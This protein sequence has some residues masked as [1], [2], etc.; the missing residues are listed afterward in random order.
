MLLRVI[1][2]GP[3]PEKVL[4]AIR[5]EMP[6]VYPKMKV[7][8]LDPLPI[9]KEAY[10]QWRKQYDAEKIMEILGKE[11]PA[12][13][14]DEEVPTLLV[15][16]YDLY[17]KNMSFVFVLEDTQLKSGI[18][19]IARLRPEFYGER[20]SIKRLSERAVKEAVHVIGHYLGLSHCRHPFCVMAF[21]PSAEDIDR[22]QKY[23][24]N[25][26]K[27]KAAMKGMEIDG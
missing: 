13:F 2:V 18:V 4:E 12:Q 27:I 23:I 10:N 17:Y 6:T 11:K 9:P 5:K 3:V 7:K 24:C 26:C 19:S 22:K 21:S 1:P 15:T 8:V 25:G 14:I 20:A 16:D